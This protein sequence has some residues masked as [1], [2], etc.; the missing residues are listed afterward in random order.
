MKKVILTFGIILAGIF[1]ANAQ[2]KATAKMVDH[3]TQVCQLTPD[4]VSKVQP[5]VANYISARKAN[6]E[7][8]ASDP[9]GLKGADKAANKE[10]KSQLNAILTPDQIQKLKDY[11]AQRRAA[12]KGQQSGDDQDGGQQ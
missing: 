6:K 5:I 1:C 2:D 4:Q 12:R 8:Y 10:Y 7:K 11:N 3:L 9:D